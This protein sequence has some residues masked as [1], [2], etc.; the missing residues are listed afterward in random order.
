MRTVWEQDG[1]SKS[2]TAPLSLVISAFAPLADVRGTLTP[3]LLKDRGDTQLMLVDLGRGQNRLGGSALGQVYRRLEGA[4]PDLDSPADMIALFKLLKAARA[5]KLLLAYHDRSDG[6]AFAAVAEMAFAGRCGVT[7]DCG[8]APPLESLFNE[9]LGVLL[10]LPSASVARLS[11]LA[12]E[13]GLADCLVPLATL[14]TQDRIEILSHGETVF[15]APRSTLQRTWAETSYHLQS[16]RDNSD[17]A[18]EEFDGLL[19]SDDVGLHA[20]L[21]FDVSDDVSAPFIATGVR[22]RV[23]VLRE[24][25]VNGQVEMA[26][27]FDR[28]GFEAV[29]VHM[30]DLL[31]GRR[32]LEGFSTLVACGGF[33]YGDVLGAG[34]GWAKTILFNDALRAQ[35]EA[36][37]ANPNTLSLGVCNGCQMLSHLAPLIPGADNWPSFQRNRS[38][39]FEARL[40]LVR[41]EDSRSAFL[42]GMAESR[43]AVAVAHGEGRAN[44]ASD[45][46]A[47]AFAAS[48]SAALRYVDSGG[49]ATQRYPANPNGAAQALAGLSSA[50]GRVTLMMPHPERVFRACQNSWHPA[51]W[52]EDAPS[53]RLFRNAR[54]WHG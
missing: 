13:C 46:A 38:E 33:S 34:G 3:Q 11:T 26:A 28:A 43:F 53:M 49:Q 22:P 50:D 25:G 29:D 6:G 27:A 42:R 16:L 44:F 37:F 19:D 54:V 21:S 35:F 9:E 20:A 32:S 40:S 24:Q 39:Q 23:A 14:N 7:I 5:E 8:T 45:E 47:R 12:A 52:T 15:S 17:C 18:Q 10:Q 2:N 31:S 1:E 4:A 36:F 41:I 51:E 48:G 30:T